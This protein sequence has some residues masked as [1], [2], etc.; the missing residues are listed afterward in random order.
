MPHLAPA[1]SSLSLHTAEHSINVAC[2]VSPRILTEQQTWA[3]AQQPMLAS[4]PRATAFA[5][6]SLRSCRRSALSRRPSAAQPQHAATH[7]GRR[8]SHRTMAYP[9][10]RG[11]PVLGAASVLLCGMMVSWILAFPASYKL[12]FWPQLAE[13][14]DDFPPGPA[15]A[16]TITKVRRTQHPQCTE[17]RLALPKGSRRQVASGGSQC[18]IAP[19]RVDAPRPLSHVLLL[20]VCCRFLLAVPGSEGSGRA[21]PVARSRVGHSNAPAAQPSRE[22]KVAARPPVHRQSGRRRSAQHSGRHC[23]HHTARPDRGPTRHPRL[24]VHH[25]SGLRGQS[26]LRRGSSK[27]QGLRKA[28]GMDAQALCT[29][30]QRSCAAHLRDYR[31]N[32]RA[33]RVL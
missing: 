19:A 15:P 31:H 20:V 7:S 17:S 13:M 14:V 29:R 27:A 22:G 24:P 6:R 8:V 25:H 4:P 9:S 11:A 3:K 18:M 16:D 21:S 33:S 28:Q 23:A 10:K 32:A 2:V 5:L 26:C 1:R 30:H 12:G